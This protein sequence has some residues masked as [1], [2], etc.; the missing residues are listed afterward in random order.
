MPWPEGPYAPSRHEKL[1]V[2]RRTSSRYEKSS[3]P[4]GLLIVNI[5]III[6][7]IIMT[8]KTIRRTAHLEQVREVEPPPAAPAAG[9]RPAGQDAVHVLSIPHYI[10]IHTYIHTYIYRE[11]LLL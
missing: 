5:I 4:S 6:Y 3:P 1:L 2:E 11:N 7:I 8:I 9:A 10:Y